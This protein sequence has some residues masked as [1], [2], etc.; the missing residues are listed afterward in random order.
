[1]KIYK[2]LFTFSQ[3]QNDMSLCLHIEHIDTLNI[4]WAMKIMNVSKFIG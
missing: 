2:N 3:S 4:I 1:M